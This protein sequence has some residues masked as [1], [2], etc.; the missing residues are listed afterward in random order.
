MLPL[1]F[2]TLIEKGGNPNT[3]KIKLI[4]EPCPIVAEGIIDEFG[5]ENYSMVVIGR[6][7]M[8]KTEKFIGGDVSVMLLRVLKGTAGLVVTPSSRRERFSPH[9]GLDRPGELF[10]AGPRYQKRRA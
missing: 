5:T 3:V 10:H 1:P 6:Q 8:P 9:Q 4:E 7:R 2:I